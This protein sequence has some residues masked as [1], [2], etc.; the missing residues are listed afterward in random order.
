MV[1][2]YDTEWIRQEVF[3]RLKTRETMQQLR[4]EP[5]TFTKQAR[6]VTGNESCGSYDGQHNAVADAQQ[7]VNPSVRRTVT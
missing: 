7:A 3:P 6:R 5:D 4:F 1:T 2:Y